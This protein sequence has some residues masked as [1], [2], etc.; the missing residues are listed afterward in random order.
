[1]KSSQDHEKTFFKYFLSKPIYLNKVGKKFF[2]NADIDALANLAKEFYVKFGEAPSE[3]QMNALILDASSVDVP[4]TIVKQIYSENIEDYDKD[5]LKRT[6][7][8]WVKWKHFDKQLIRTV[9]Y[10]KTQN[11]TPENVEDV[12]SRAAGMISSDGKISFDA[13]VGLNFF[14][15]EDHVQGTTDKIKTGWD[16]IDRITGGGYDKKSLVV[17]AGEQGIGKSVWLANDA[18]N[19]M[20][21]GHNVAFITAEMSDK[22]VMKRIGANLLNITMS[23]YDQ[24]STNRDFIKRKLERVT[25]G[26]MPP[27]KL[28]IKEFPT[29]QASV[30]DIEA[31]LKTLEESQD[32]KVNVLIVDY[33]NILA[34]YR[35]PNTEN[36]YIKI[37]QIAEDLRALAVKYNML[38]ISATQLNRSGWNS[39]EV[40]IEN[41]AESA[42]LAHTVDVMYA[43]IQDAAM[44]IDRQYWLKVLK[45]RDGEGKGNRCMFNVNYEYMRLMETEQVT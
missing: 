9:E 39:T 27:G 24:K 26:V 33:I 13:D 18:A 14:N 22:K 30:L 25:K 16:F 17:Y 21:M 10:V 8:A 45:M 4:D 11:V 19:F 28:F 43:L 41:I 2:K 29:S 6:A 35:N 31:Y 36:T 1:M 37:K 40:N 34:N 23:E 38:I 42:G 15:P 32:H 44:H 20:R 3:K 12:V 5:W 7:E